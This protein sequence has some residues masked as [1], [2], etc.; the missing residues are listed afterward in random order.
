MFSIVY[1]S[2]PLSRLTKDT[3][4]NKMYGGE[5]NKGIDEKHV[6]KHVSKRALTL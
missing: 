6:G 5:I 3:K 2:R 4:D 1:Q